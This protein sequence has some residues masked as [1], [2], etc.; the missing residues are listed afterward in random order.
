MNE[1]KNIP[2]ESL[3]GE[4]ELFGVDPESI[5]REIFGSKEACGTINFILDGKTYS[6][7]EDPSDGYRSSLDYF[8]ESDKK[9]NHTFPPVKVLARHK[10]K[11]EFNDEADILELADVTNGNVI[12]EVGTAHS[13]DY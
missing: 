10:T 2:F 7:C 4:H 5:E 6:G 9:V 8:V 12:L 1:E 13:D 3:I 11:E